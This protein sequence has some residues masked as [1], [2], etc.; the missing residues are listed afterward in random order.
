MS[1]DTIGTPRHHRAIVASRAAHFGADSP[2]TAVAR[3]DLRAANLAKAIRELV[4]EAP[5]LTRAQR[6]QLALMLRPRGAA[7]AQ[8]AQGGDGP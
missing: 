2:Q 8:P 6:D 3:R 1:T 4:D 5:P 7:A